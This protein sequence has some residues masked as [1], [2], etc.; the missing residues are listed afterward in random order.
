M[1]TQS[2]AATQA[3]P[4][5]R[6]VYQNAFNEEQIRTPFGKVQKMKPSYGFEYRTHEAANI[7]T[8]WDEAWFA[9]YE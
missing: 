9:S 7:S 8:N 6:V 4:F 5:L 3:I 1:K 2:S